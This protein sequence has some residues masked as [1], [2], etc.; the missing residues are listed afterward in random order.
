MRSERSTAFQSR[1]AK[2]SRSPA[3]RSPM[4]VSSSENPRGS[5]GG[6]SSRGHAAGR[7][8]RGAAIDGLVGVRTLDVTQLPPEWSLK[9]VR[10]RGVIVSAGRFVLE[11]GESI[12]DI[13]V[14]IVPR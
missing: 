6:S 2:R 3:R 11:A 9:E 1:R 8:A 13:E 4:F 14:V 12:D 10:R 7:R 5:Q